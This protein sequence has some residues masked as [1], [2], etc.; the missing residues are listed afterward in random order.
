MAN[1]RIADDPDEVGKRYAVDLYL[2]TTRLKT[3]ARVDGNRAQA[4][5]A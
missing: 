5:L 2:S 4:R 1:I 3:A